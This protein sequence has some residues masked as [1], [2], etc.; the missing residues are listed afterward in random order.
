MP[1]RKFTIWGKNK[2]GEA[3]CF[4]LY[5]PEEDIEDYLAR[6]KKEGWTDLITDKKPQRS[7]W[8]DEEEPK[9]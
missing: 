7:L 8:D 4:A 6:A 9:A 5:A 2:W 3:K 1:G